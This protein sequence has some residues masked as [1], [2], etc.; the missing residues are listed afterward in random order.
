MVIRILAIAIGFVLAYTGLAGAQSWSPLYNQPPFVAGQPLLLTDGTVMVQ[1]TST[2]QWWRLTPDSL[3]SFVNGTWTQL[4]T[5]PNGHAPLYYASAVLP[6]GRVVVVG[7]EYNNGVNVE[8]TQGA[9]YNPL[10][11]SWT[12]IAPPSGVSQ[13]GD[14]SSVVLPNGTFML[15]PCCSSSAAYLLNPTNL[16]W[17]VTGFGKAD[18]NSEEGWTLLPN[19]KVLT[20]DVHG[21]ASE[22]YNPAT[23]SWSSAGS[24]I[25]Q[26][27][28]FSNL[29]IGPAVLRPDGT[30]FA[31]G[32]TS[33]TAIYNP[34]SGAWSAGPTFPNN[35]TVGDGPAALL[36]SGNVLVDAA[37][38]AFGNG[39]H[40]F[41]FNGSSLTEE[42]RPPNAPGEPSFAGRMLVLP[43]GEIL[44]TDGTTDVE[45]YTANGTY[46]SAW[47][48]VI[49]SS[50]ASVTAG[51]ANYFVS[52]TQFNGLSQGAMYGDDAQ[53]ATNYPLARITNNATGHV[54]YARTHG[55]STMAVA[56]GGASVSTLMDVPGNTESGSSTL[57]VVA[58]GIPSNPVAIQVA[59]CPTCPADFALSPSSQFIYG[60]QGQT[61][62]ITITVT[63]INGFSGVVSLSSSDPADTFSPPSTTTSSTMWVS[64]D[65]PYG[66]TK[67][68]TIT[69]TSGGI[70]HTTNVQWWSE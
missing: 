50:P 24:T 22:L 65:L 49:S 17:T 14:A 59:S 10:T 16:T 40:F 26:L 66:G 56:T 68:L 30:V 51:T 42:S 13:I 20:V 47:Q 46:Q 5:L 9:I 67:R 64:I 18:T 57:Q 19:G 45:I 2:G 70:S 36:P 55:H 37:P 6:D 35:L 11:N 58:N 32:G 21:I 28:D 52:G 27:P 8:N 38:R 1:Q 33:N 7:G 48:P 4:A 60:L 23:G 31:T 25:V 44:F 62:G 29:E 3:G 54:K 15:G 34:A 69:G 61:I 53:S 39:A 12:S 43:T 63:P 41:E